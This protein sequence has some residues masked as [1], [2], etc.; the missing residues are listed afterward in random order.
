[1]KV[2]R[3][4]FLAAGSAISLSLA[5]C[6]EELSGGGSIPDLP[7]TGSVA[8][9]FEDFDER[10][11]EFMTERDIPGGVLGVATDGEVYVERGYG[12]RDK[13]LSRPVEPETLFRI[14]SLSKAFTRAAIHTLR[15]REELD[16]DRPVFE[17]LDL[18]PLPGESYNDE[19]DDITAG[20][21]LTHRGGWD[22]EEA[23]DPA[24]S[25]LDIALERGWEEPPDEKQLVRYML[26]EP[27]QFTPGR[28]H[29]YSNIGYIVLGLLVEKVS[30]HS[31]HA[32]LEQE[33]FGPYGITD[34]AVGRSLPENRPERET[35]YFDGRVC[36]NVAELSPLELLRCPDGGFH[37]ESTAASGGHIVSVS[38][39]LEW[40]S[41]YWL[42]GRKRRGEDQQ[43]WEYNGTLPGTFSTALQHRGFDI[44]VIFNQRGYDPNYDG[45]REQLLAAAEGYANT[46]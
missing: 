11:H 1:M 4:E 14:A 28:G 19:L 39:F 10:V 17:I 20:H 38:A 23:Y 37:L 44:V 5:G 3:R 42:N 43:R 15:R 13:S 34:I 41:E 35:Y 24:F 33:L 29:S 16:L 6:T 12:Y 22:R 31:Y 40:M 2:H 8:S 46:D 25:Q 27:L 7:R 26:S 36:P 45:I 30:G 18:D 9:G 21:L 32:F